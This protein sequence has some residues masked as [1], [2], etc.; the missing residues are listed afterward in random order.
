M[1][2]DWVPSEEFLEDVCLMGNIQNSCKERLKKEL[3]KAQKERKKK[4]LEG[5]EKAKKKEKEIKKKFDVGKRKKNFKKHVSREIRSYIKNKLEPRDLEQNEAIEFLH[6]AVKAALFDLESE[7]KIEK[8]IFHINKL[9]KRAKE[10]VEEGYSNLPQAQEI[11]NQETRAKSLE[12]IHGM[13]VLGATKKRGRRRPGGKR[14]R[15]IY[16]VQLKK[17]N[18]RKGQ[19]PKYPEEFLIGGLIGAYE[20][21][22]GK[23]VFRRWSNKKVGPFV[24]IANFVF[25]EIYKNTGLEIG[26][27]EHTLRKILERNKEYYSKNSIKTG[28]L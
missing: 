12:L 1:K 9:P 16:Q 20:I 6:D 27:P 28:D 22:T 17:F 4:G 10:W 25:E 7:R 3:E 23:P 2:Y 19:P 21:A 5:D 13:T 26:S 11:I 24:K 18:K 14:S 15:D 8:V